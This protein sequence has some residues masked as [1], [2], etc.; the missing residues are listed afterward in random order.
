M[1]RILGIKVLEGCE[2]IIRKIL[3]E[4]T[5]YLL[6]SD[7][8]ESANELILLPEE[9]NIKTSAC[10]DLYDVHFK[11][12]HTLHVNVSAIVGKNGDGKSTIVEVI[13]SVLNNFAINCG[14]L[15]DQESLRYIGGLNAILYYELDSIVYAIRSYNGG[16]EWF[17]EGQKITDIESCGEEL[18][19]KITLKRN[20]IKE[21]LYTLVINYSLYG[22]NS[23]KMPWIESLFHKNDAYQTPVVINPMRTKGNIDV[24]REEFLSRQ[25]LMTLFT[26]M[27]EDMTKDDIIEI[28]K[29]S[30]TESAIGY[31]FKLEDQSKFLNKT[32]AEF[33]L[34]ARAISSSW[35]EVKDFNKYNNFIT[36]YFMDKICNFVERF[37]SVMADYHVLFQFATD[38]IDNWTQNSNTEIF[39]YVS[40]VQ[41]RIAKDKRLADVYRDHLRHLRLIKP[42]NKRKL[43]YAQMYRLILVVT[44]WR[45]ITSNNRFNMCHADLN[46][47]ILEEGKPRNRAMLYVLYKIISIMETYSGM[48]TFNYLSDEKFLCMNEGWIDDYTY[49]QI[50]KDIENIY[51]THDYRTLKL[52][53]TINFLA[54]EDEYFGTNRCNLVGITD[55]THYIN[56]DD[57]REALP[58]VG[59]EITSYLPSPIFVGDIILNNGVDNYALGTLSSGMTQRLNS[60]GSFIYHL[61]NLDDEHQ[62]GDLISYNNLVA[63]FEEVELYFHPEYQKA[64]L[65]YLLKQIEHSNQKRFDNL[66]I[67]F[68]THSPFILS[69]VLRNNILCVKNGSPKKEAP[70]LTFAANI[71]DILRQPFFMEKGTIGDYSQLVI[72]KIIRQL[73]SQGDGE[74]FDEVANESSYILD[75][76]N[77][78]DEPIIRNSLL[79]EHARVFKSHNAIDGRIQALEDEINRLKQMR[80][81]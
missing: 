55:Y 70:F 8:K 58:K 57:L 71:H 36:G 19:K 41:D 4:N 33:F 16:L 15:N 63:I 25:R 1:F 40:L 12:G 31:A 56:F 39:H 27:D 3:K 66:H 11:N 37:G 79:S 5:L 78:I 53:Q 6:T 18:E 47:V 52:W 23:E 64:Y 20:H 72:N 51:N 61:R 49:K 60:V 50:E 21:L 45:I 28:R 42:R 75:L 76:I 59:R 7:Y 34:K 29:I 35:Y 69:D 77:S 48:M 43:N 24:N 46:Q 62:E 30:D 26:V 32:I 13:I 22:Y 73:R 38:T 81:E 9:K 10:E 2:A 14:Y 65:S 68:V 54:R 17:R 67:I 44:I 80:G 74:R